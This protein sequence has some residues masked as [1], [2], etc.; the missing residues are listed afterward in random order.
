MATSLANSREGSA[1]GGRTIED[2]YIQHREHHMHTAS[3]D[4]AHGGGS[5]HS[6]AQDSMSTNQ[7]PYSQQ[8]IR[9]WVTPMYYSAKKSGAL[10]DA[11]D[12]DLALAAQRQQQ[13]QEWMTQHGPG[14]S[15]YSSPSSRQGS[16]Q[17]GA[18][19]HTSSGVLDSYIHAQATAKFGNK[20]KP[21]TS[22]KAQRASSPS[23]LA[24]PAISVPMVGFV[25][26]DLSTVA[27][28]ELEHT[29]DFVRLHSLRSLGV[30]EATGG[31]GGGDLM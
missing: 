16:R 14:M 8:V 3:V 30:L 21:S 18:R 27:P 19:P 15:T 17:G 23:G 26:G 25:D 22:S 4:L 12:A 6:A 5:M 28:P 13:Y 9:R 24:A 31:G 29:A 7:V 1:R 11:K 20:S 2:H 10:K